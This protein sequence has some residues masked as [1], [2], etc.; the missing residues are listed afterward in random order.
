MQFLIFNLAEIAF[1]ASLPKAPNNYNPKKNYERAI[2]RRNW[3]IDRM[4]Q[5]GFIKISDLSFKNK[6]LEV[7]DRDCLIRLGTSINPITKNKSENFDLFDYSFSYNNQD[8]KG[9]IKSHD[10]ELFPI[11]YEPI[12]ITLLPKNNVDLGRGFGQKVERE[13]Y[14]G[15]VGILLDGRIKDS[16]NQTI[17]KNKEKIKEWYNKTEVYSI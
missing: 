11:P 13:I 4:Y 2:E 14:G 3:V 10:L 5:N 1:L 12:N 15:E 17:I 16:D 6:P 7:F 9:T 8:Y